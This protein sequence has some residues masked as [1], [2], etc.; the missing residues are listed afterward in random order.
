M[1]TNLAWYKFKHSFCKIVSYINITEP[2]K[3]KHVTSTFIAILIFE[4]LIGFIKVF[5]LI[6]V[7][8]SNANYDYW[9]WLMW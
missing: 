1:T 9:T 8:I 7:R 2:Y 6:K 4:Q 3:L 5:K